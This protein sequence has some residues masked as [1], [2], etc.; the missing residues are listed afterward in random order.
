[1]SMAALAE[2]L[3]AMARIGLGA[4]APFLLLPLAVA[5]LGRPAA[6]IAHGVAGLVEVVSA[7]AEQLAKALLALLAVLVGGAVLLRYGFGVSLTAWGEAALY[8]HALA[9]LLAAAA[10][11]GRDAHVRVDVFYA[12]MSPKAKAW[13][14]LLAYHVLIAPALLVLLHVSGPY[15]A[16][17]WRIGERSAEADGLPLLFLLKTAIPIFAVLLLAQASVGAARAACTLRGLESAKER[18]APGAERPA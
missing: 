17:S 14:N 6:E 7:G 15:V 12:R 11:L 8:A 10:A 2:L 13:V 18:F 16:Q 4:L 3:G 1:V 5:I 9:F